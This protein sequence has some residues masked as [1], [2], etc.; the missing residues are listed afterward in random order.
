MN[1]DCSACEI[2]IDK[3]KYKRDRT[4]CKS[5]YNKNK[6]KK[7]IVSYQ[8]PKTENGNNNNNH[9][10][11]MVGPSFSGKTFL[12]LKILSRIPNRD[13]FIITKSPSEQYSN[14]KNKEIGGEMKP[15][16]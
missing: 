2:K 3:K 15:P 16:S 5:C 10:T 7:T 4:V 6:R 12:L 9:R 1:R 11:L 14:S 8:Q 13:V